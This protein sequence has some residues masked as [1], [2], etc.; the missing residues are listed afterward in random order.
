MF[1]GHSDEPHTALQMDEVKQKNP[2]TLNWM[3]VD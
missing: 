3:F 1:V 2:P